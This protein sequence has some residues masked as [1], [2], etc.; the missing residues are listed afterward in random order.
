MKYFLFRIQNIEES[1]K[2]KMVTNKDQIVNAGKDT[3]KT[4]A[5]ETC[6]YLSINGNY[7]KTFQKY[8]LSYESIYCY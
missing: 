2:R 7:E 5:D 8:T 4:N 6:C 3:A 1:D